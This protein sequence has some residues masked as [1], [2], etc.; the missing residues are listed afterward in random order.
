MIASVRGGLVHTMQ[1]A[2]GM[3]PYARRPLGRA[4]S[5]LRP[6]LAIAEAL[7]RQ[8]RELAAN[9]ESTEVAAIRM[10]LSSPLAQRAVD[11]LRDQAAA[12]GEAFALVA[13]LIP[14]ENTIRAAMD[15]AA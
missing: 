8:A 11:D 5:R 2:G 1:T 10:G 12:M 13:A 14:M 3:V 9:A 7:G 4:P 6:F 15:E